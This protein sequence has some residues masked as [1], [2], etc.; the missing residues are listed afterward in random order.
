MTAKVT[1]IGLR[2]FDNDSTVGKK[3]PKGIVRTYADLCRRSYSILRRDPDRYAVHFHDSSHECSD[4]LS[5]EVW[6]EGAYFEEAVEMVVYAHFV[7]KEGEDPASVVPPVSES[8]AAG[9]QDP[10]ISLKD[11]K[12]QKKKANGS[13][14]QAELSERRGT[15]A[16]KDPNTSG[17]VSVDALRAGE[18]GSELSFTLVDDSNGIPNKVLKRDAPSLKKRKHQA[19]PVPVAHQSSKRQKCPKDVPLR[20]EYVLEEAPIFPDDYFE[21]TGSAI[22]PFPSLSIGDDAD[23]PSDICAWVQNYVHE[24]ADRDLERRDLSLE[25]RRR[26][27]EKIE[28][29]VFLIGPDTQKVYELDPDSIVPLWMLLKLDRNALPERVDGRIFIDYPQGI[30]PSDDNGITVIDFMYTSMTKGLDVSDWNACSVETK[31]CM[32][33]DQ[34]RS[35]V[36]K[37]L[38]TQQQQIVKNCT[39]IDDTLG[40]DLRLCNSDGR[41]MNV[42]QLNQMQ[43]LR[44]WAENLKTSPAKIVGRVEVWARLNFGRL[45]EMPDEP[46]D[47][48]VAHSDRTTNT[49]DADP[50]DFTANRLIDGQG[51]G[52]S[53]RFLINV[54][55]EPLGDLTAEPRGHVTEGNQTAPTSLSTEVLLILDVIDHIHL[56]RHGKDGLSGLAATTDQFT[57]ST[58]S[59]GTAATIRAKTTCKQLLQEIQRDINERVADAQKASGYDR[60][61]MDLLKGGVTPS[62][63]IDTPTGCV[64]IRSLD[65]PVLEMVGF[66]TAPPARTD[67]LTDGQTSVNEDLPMDVQQQAEGRVFLHHAEGLKGGGGKKTIC[68]CDEPNYGVTIQCDDAN[69]SRSCRSPCEQTR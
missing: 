1:T 25:V 13:I 67:S 50:E 17:R 47:H 23:S 35:R 58:K 61:V 4:S 27:Q 12:Q 5:D 48:N 33:V 31:P 26:L 32:T 20:L 40:F 46:S 45:K 53:K 54:Q 63:W 68:S 19:D 65:T 52:E 41:W 56:S 2:N 3:I 37:D 60:R 7:R 16:S 18:E 66:K 14:P 62:V 64:K 9:D 29:V 49:T 6:D 28:I 10:R 59:L 69:V 34:V 24:Q 30:W 43:S 36:H 38:L 55:T 44:W 8:K 15:R 39:S 22:L 42:N 57:G 21:R 11:K 51:S